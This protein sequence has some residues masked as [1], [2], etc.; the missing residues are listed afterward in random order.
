MAESNVALRG[1]RMMTTRELRS[2]IAAAMRLQNV[3]VLL[4][5]GASHE[6][7][8][9]TMSEVWTDFE[10]SSPDGL[11]WLIAEG[12][13]TKS[14]GDAA[15]VNVET[16]LDTLR[17]A[18]AEWERQK[19]KGLDK[20]RL[21]RLALLRTLVSATL[22]DRKLFGHPTR[23]DDAESLSTHRK[24]LGRLVASRQ[25]G[26]PAPWAFT[27]NYD[28]ALEWAAESMRLM[29]I[30][31]F[32]GLHNRTFAPHNF[33][34]AYRNVL[35]RGEARFGSYHFYLA[36][37]HGSLT[38]R[39]NQEGHVREVACNAIWGK[40]KKLV[41]NEVGA[42]WPDLV[43]MPGTSKYMQTTDYLFGE[44]FRRLGDFLARPQT[45][46][47]I[48]GYGFGDVHVNRVL[49]SALQNPT[50]QMIIYA[51]EVSFDKAAKIDEVSLDKA[52]SELSKFVKL[53]SPQV[54]VVGNA[55][56]AHF[57]EFVRDLPEPTLLDEFSE[58]ARA[59][60][61]PLLKLS[62]VNETTDDDE[63][64]NGIGPQE[65]RRGRIDL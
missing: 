40:L 53:Q 26:Q 10:Q 57:E 58:R 13:V 61:A 24:L 51:P 15:G 22:L 6:V 27:L 41:D 50:L 38:W 64:E 3:G 55:D 5:A 31:G 9:K 65:V 20:L 23:C 48:N 60:L 39:L 37:L 44:L 42:E 30:N 34:L 12:F 43:V 8:G 14:D 35:A 56:R 21:H 33:D 17:T 47:L 18:E 46:I 54:T 63:M 36:K 25:P 49:L 28:L 1:E 11:Q 29:A 4:G 59:L 2:H 16:L 62:A 45:T 32:S 7:G 19:A 52:G